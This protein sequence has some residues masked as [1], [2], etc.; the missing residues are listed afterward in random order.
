MSWEERLARADLKTLWLL[1]HPVGHSLSPRIQNAALQALGAPWVYLAA[2][3]DPKNFEEAARGLGQLGAVGANVTVPFKE[4][5]W[6]LCDELSD[7]ARVMG[8]CNVLSF[9]DGKIH[10]DNTDGVGWLRALELGVPDFYPRRALVLGAGGAARAI[11]LALVEKG[12]PQIFILNRSFERANALKEQFSGLGATSITVTSL[13]RFPQLVSS[14]DLVVQ[15]TS[16]GLDRLSSP[17]KLPLVWPKEV[18]L[19]ELI[20]GEPTPL[21]KAVRERGAMVCDGLAMLVFQAAESLARWMNC[22]FEEIPWRV[23]G[24]AVGLMATP[25]FDGSMRGCGPTVEAIAFE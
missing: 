3:L 4:R 17:V 9:V 19:S 2:D 11:L 1:G 8:A 6:A 12:V 15:T 22:S 7:R 23:M 10:G 5:A 20:Y 14:G 18:V 21:L 24:Q 16:V 25:I 13:D